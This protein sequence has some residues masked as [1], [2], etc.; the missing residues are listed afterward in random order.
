M[1]LIKITEQN[2]QGAVSARELHLFLEIET[3]FNDWIKRMFEYGFSENADYQVL[4]KNEYNPNGGRPETDYALS[5]DCAKEISMIQRS[6]KGKQ[7]RQ[8]FIECEKKLKTQAP[9]SFSAA[10]KLAYESQLKIEEQQK[11]L[12]YQKPLV[13]FAEALQIS[14]H[15]ILIGELSKILKQNNIDT[16]QNR[17]FEW[18]RG[19]GYLMKYGEMRNQPT[20]KAMDLGLFEVKTRTINNPDGSVRVTKTTKVTPKGQQYFVNKF[21]SIQRKSA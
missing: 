12:E 19:N 14:E 1:E 4:L 18:L 9:R 15:S 6:E 10:L 8:Y 21:L 16:G 7:A 5:I 17:M 13:I 11:Q 3:R 2:G 20:Q